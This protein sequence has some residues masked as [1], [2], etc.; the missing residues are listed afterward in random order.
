MEEGLEL[1]D[2]LVISQVLVE[3]VVLKV[4]DKFKGEGVVTMRLE[5]SLPFSEVTFMLLSK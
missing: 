5:I 3:F 2:E 1:S 4:V